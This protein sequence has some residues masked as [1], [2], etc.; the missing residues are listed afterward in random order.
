[1]YPLDSD[2]VYYHGGLWR[3]LDDFIMAVIQITVLL[4]EGRALLQ[5][6]LMSR[7]TEWIRV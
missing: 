1:M 3:S 4:R 2:R 5:G 7:E 6:W